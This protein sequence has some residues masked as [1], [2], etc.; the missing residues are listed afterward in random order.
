MWKRPWGVV[1]GVSICVGLVIVGIVLQLT[2]GNINWDFFAMP[3]NIA[4]LAIY[5]FILCVLYALRQRIY[6][7]RWAMSFYAAIPSFIA[8]VVMTFLMGII[9]QV[10]HN[11][12]NGDVLGFSKMV[13]CWPFVLVY[14]W[15]A[16]IL[17]LV[18]IR[19]ICRF[20]LKQIPFLC[21]HLGMFIVL[22]CAVLGSADMNRVTMH[23]K[24]GQT[25]WR[26]MDKRGEVMELPLAIEL[27]DFTIDEYP[28][29]LMIIN[30]TTGAQLAEDKSEQFLVEDSASQGILS[31][32][33]IQVLEVLDMAASMV[34][35]DSIRFVEWH[36]TGAAS[37]V[38]V[39]V[40]SPDGNVVR[41]GWVS[42]GSFAFPYHSLRLNDEWSLVMIPREPKRFAST[43]QMYSQSGVKFDTIIEVNKP[44]EIEGWKVYQLSYDEQKGR[45][46]D[47]SIFELVSDP[48]LPWV[49]AGIYMMVIGALFMFVF[50][51]RNLKK[52]KE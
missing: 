29:K 6:F 13:S 18:S 48:W 26:V 24:V 27:K 45:W 46:S 32:W 31:G 42:C 3:L 20:S 52:T 2:N 15:A 10:P 33:K 36:S 25:E 41:E 8:V 51:S 43:V 40:T 14:W 44:V 5:V 35:G 7:I 22:V 19:S 23:T 34:E 1:E 28:P 38:K 11:V 39:K 12:D 4:I 16:T 30:N 37:A 49:Y 17:G 9:R 50:P 47:I 21:N